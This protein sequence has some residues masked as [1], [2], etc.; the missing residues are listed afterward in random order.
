MNCL[1]CNTPNEPGATTCIKCGTDLSFL[2]VQT[3]PDKTVQYLLIIMGWEYF[4]WILWFVIAKLIIPRSEA[5]NATQFYDIAGWG[6]DIV[7]IILL[8][9][10]ANLA[11]NPM[12]KGFLF[13]FMA[14]RIGLFI[15]YRLA[16]I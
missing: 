6:M 10:F 5:A 2:P 11:K 12:A 13:L 9:I 1:R 4:C 14:I 8:L 16:N 15:F 7:S 3:T